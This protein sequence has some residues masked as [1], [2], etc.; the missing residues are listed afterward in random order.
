MKFRMED[1]AGVAV[2]DTV[3]DREAEIDGNTRRPEST[4]LSSRWICSPG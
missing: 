2:P 3:E 4:N 1:A